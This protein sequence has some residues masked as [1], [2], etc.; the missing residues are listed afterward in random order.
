MWVSF[1]V[2]ACAFLSWGVNNNTM[3]Q[4]SRADVLKTRS[5]TVQQPLYTEYRGVRLNM[6]AEQVKSQL[7]EP[8]MKVSDQYFYVFSDSET[9]QI[10]YDAAGKVRAVS[11][12]FLGGLGAPE[13][14]L[15]V[16]QEVQ[17]KADGSIYQVARYEGLGFWVSYNRSIGPVASVTVTIQRIK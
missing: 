13:Y 9:A 16:G 1:V 2:T 12:D 17:V 10:F 14:R 11:A 5:Q 3:A 7:G 8:A 15:V 6:T 4:T